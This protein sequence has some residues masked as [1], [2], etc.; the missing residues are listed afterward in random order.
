MNPNLRKAN[1]QAFIKAN[2]K[3]DTRQLAFQKNPF[4]GELTLAEL[5]TQIEVQK[6]ALQKI[7]EWADCEGLIYPKLS[8]EQ[9]SSAPIAQFKSTLIKGKKLADLTGGLGVDTY[10]FAQQFEKVIHVEPNEELHILVK[11]NFRRLG[12]ENVQFVN[13]TAEQFLL[14]DWQADAV[15]IDPSRRDENEKK[16]YFLENCVP[17][18]IELLPQI[19]EHTPTLLLK[20]APM[21]DLK[22][23]LQ[24]LEYVQ[25]TWIVALENEVKEL[26]FKIKK[27]TISTENISTL[28]IYQNTDNQ[29]FDFNLETEDQLE[30]NYAL[31]QK[32]LIEPNKAILKAGAFQ[33]FAH[34]YQ[35][36]KLHP[37]THLYT[38]DELPLPSAQ[39]AGRVFEVLAQCNYQKK[40]VLKNLTVSKAN[41]ATR[42]FP[43]SPEQM[44]KKLGLNTGGSYYLWGI[45]DAENQA[46]ILITRKV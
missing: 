8:L 25:Q 13:Q 27:N 46:K 11:E 31:P 15:F 22:R 28:N 1:V 10:F 3:A 32:Y 34:H 39:I 20:A 29:V 36:N 23:A 2:L 26:L 16:V 9:S 24:Q 30:V 35:L 6:K 19:F 41:I 40:D 12:I 4:E 42:N 37:H 17:N 44:Y 45:R 21:L 33:S 14:Q 5:L 18:V 7:P 38:I 43:D